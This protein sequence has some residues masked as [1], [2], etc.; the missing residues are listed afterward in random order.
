MTNWIQS[1]NPKK[2]ALH[3]QLGIPADQKI[4][5]PLLSKIA[6][7]A[8]GKKIKVGSKSVTVTTLLKNRCRFAL[9]M[10]RL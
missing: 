7:S 9:T 4:P 10:K 1:A 5:M 3:K 8:P 6:H 2:G